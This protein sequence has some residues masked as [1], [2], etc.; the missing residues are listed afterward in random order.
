M[1]M[2]TQVSIKINAVWPKLLA[3]FY[4]GKL[5]KLSN[6]SEDVQGCI[7]LHPYILALLTTY[8]CF[9]SSSDTNR[10]A[11]IVSPAAVKVATGLA[12]FCTKLQRSNILFLLVLALVICEFRH[13]TIMVRYP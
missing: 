11:C 8:S 7:Q 10:P 4:F 2:H 9:M 6:L 12:V 13:I 5:M 3:G 1:T